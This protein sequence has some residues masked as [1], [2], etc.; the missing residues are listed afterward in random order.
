MALNKPELQTNLFNL[1]ND[2]F[3]QT[4]NASEARQVFA[5]EL[6]DII[7]AYVKSALIT[8]PPSA[9]VVTGS[10]TTQTNPSPIVLNNAIS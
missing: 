8:I 1:M 6:G 4:E 3:A 7:D 9:V 2:A 5:N 10:A